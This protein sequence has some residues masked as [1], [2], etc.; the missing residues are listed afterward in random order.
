MDWTIFLF[1]LKWVLLGLI[2]IFLG[3]LF[4]NVTREMRSRLPQSPRSTSGISYGRL[5]VLH[6]GS[7]ANLHQ[8]M[9]LILQPETRLGSKR[10]NTLVLRD[11]YISGNHARLQWDGVAWWVEDLGSTNGTFINEQRIPSGSAQPLSFGAHLRIG[12]MS[13]EMME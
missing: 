13:F 6:A 9:V 3:V 1:V 10:E 7:D 11:Q 12:E 4:L 2:Y 5:K 8:G